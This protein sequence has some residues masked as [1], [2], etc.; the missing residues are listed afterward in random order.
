MKKIIDKI[1]HNSIRNKL[2]FAIFLIIIIMEVLT[3]GIVRFTVIRE[4]E[5]DIVSDNRQRLSQINKNLNMVF[6][7]I[8]E[9]FFDVYENVLHERRRSR[10]I[11]RN[12]EAFS[13]KFYGYFFDMTASMRTYSY[14]HSLVLVTEE[15]Q[16]Y[17]QS[18]E[19]GLHLTNDDLFKKAETLCDK[20]SICWSGILSDDYYFNKKSETHLISAAIPVQ[21]NYHT[22]AYI[23]VNLYADRIEKFLTDSQE[24]ENVVIQLKES[25]FLYGDLS[26]NNFTDKDVALLCSDFMRESFEDT[27]RYYVMTEKI[28]ATQWKITMIYPKTLAHGFLWD[29]LSMFMILSVVLVISLISFSTL[30]V[31]EVTHPIQ[32]V[33]QDIQR[34]EQAGQLE[35]ISFVPRTQDEMAILVF[36]YNKLVARIRENMKQIEEEQNLSNSLYL[37]TLQMQ[38]NPHFLHNTLE[39]LK[40]MI[41]MNN[42]RAKEMIIAVGDFYKTSLTG[43]DDRT[44]LSTELLQIDSYLKIMQIRYSDKINY[45]IN[46]EDGLEDNVALKLTLQ[47]IVENAIYHGLKQK[48]GKGTIRITAYKSEGYAVIDIYDNGAGIEAENLAGLQRRLAQA[49]KIKNSDHIGLQNV[50]QRIRLRFGTGYGLRI[51]SE[52]NIYTLVK[53]ILP[54]RIFRQMEECTNVQ[55]LDSR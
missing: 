24:Y 4:M 11:F 39:G 54:L 13:I 17:C 1:A 15:G 25:E 16:R 34:A 52:R 3:I 9:D 53:V 27:V 20:N 29:T 21:E 41:E 50:Q 40:F 49:D 42:P 31:Y 43:I 55:T 19:A 48:R 2:L 36:S 22:V 38:I 18:Y 26:M 5:N 47:P 8:G 6:S 45:E 37:L 32:R 44:N 14:I 46:V 28:P 51:E 23:I 33:T 7:Q 10:N 12:R 35:E 30:I